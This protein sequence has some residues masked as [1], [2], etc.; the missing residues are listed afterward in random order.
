MKLNPT[1]YLVSAVVLAAFFLASSD[2]PPNARTGAPGEGLC[3]TGCHG[4]GGFSGNVAIS[5]IP[6]TVQAGQTYTVTLTTTAT[7][8]SPSVGGFQI[9]ALNSGNMNI[10]DLIVLNAAETGTDFSGGREYMEHRGD[11]NYSGNTVSW[12][13]DWQAPAGPNNE[14]ITF[15]FSSVMANN[16]SAFSGDNAVNSSF[17]VLLQAPTPPV[18]AIDNI[19]PVS[20][21]G[22][23]DGAISASASGGTPP[24]NFNWS[25]GMS[26]AS[27][28]GLT[29]GTYTLT[30]SDQAGQS[31]TIQ[32][33][34]SQP[35]A[36][37]VT[38]QSADPLTC[39]APAVV[40]V[41]ASGGTPGYTYDWSNGASG[42]QASLTLA[43]LPATVTVTD[44]NGCTVT[45]TIS[46]VPTDLDAPQ[47]QALGGTITCQ[48]PLVTLSGAGSSEGPCFSYQWTGPGGF[49]AMT[50]N[51]QV[52]TPGTY[53]LVV[54]NTCNGCTASAVAIVTEDLDFP[55]I[56]L[57]GTDT[58][59]CLQPVV[60]I[61]AG[62]LPGQSYQWS[63]QNGEI[64]Y[65]AD[66]VI[67]GVS[68]AGTYTVV[69]TKDQSGCT[70]TASV[71]VAGIPDPVWQLDTLKNLRCFGDQDGLAG[72]SGLGGLPPYVFLWPDSSNATFRADLAAGNYLVS[73][74]D[75]NGCLG[76][77]TLV[78]SGP[79]EIV[80]NLS[81]T[82]ESAPGAEDGTAGTAPAGGTPPYAI[83][84]GNGE[85]TNVISGLSPG[86][87]GITV[88]D[89]LGCTR[90]SEVIIQPFGCSLAANV[91]YDPPVCF[92][93]SGSITLEITGANG[94][95]DI[96]W[97]QG[98]SGPVLE[99]VP[100]GSYG[101]EITDSAGCFLQ[102]SA[103]LTQPEAFL[104]QPD[105]IWPSSGDLPDGAI[106]L[107]VSGGTPPYTFLWLDP[108]GEEAG[109]AE[110]L[111]GAFPGLYYFE[112]TDSNGC[113]GM[114][115][116]T[117]ESV[118][119]TPAWSDQVRL[120]PNPVGDLLTLELPAGMYFQLRLRD[121]WGR[122]LLRLDHLQGEQ[123]MPMGQLPAGMYILQV[124]DERGVQATY[125]VLR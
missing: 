48:Q 58:L 27:I 76:Q 78:I 4:G 25:N 32:A 3:S 60:E 37:L 44:D 93:D 79:Q 84:W 97:S 41:A 51:P 90:S 43:D 50:L 35:P 115:A 66:S 83:L 38:E 102:I 99:Q 85:T 65:G 7:S 110:D 13:F 31:A 92:G 73:I 68:K 94:P 104:I 74:T 5:G 49:S 72:L 19:T 113:Q 95:V 103:V 69:V 119:L 20:C 24:Y 86:T 100:A 67:V 18:P 34:V 2:N 117:I 70:A 1:L 122:E 47:A 64:A 111:V 53:T 88:T 57:S 125:R 12:T 16:N 11:K 114:D 21:N 55:L 30:V 26:G 39:A 10:G 81:N 29:A 91:L 28:S 33:T 63:T 36:L 71:T 105:S 45:L 42:P 112:V 62:F 23:N 82:D 89:S 77:D 9:V 75:Q 109:T 124:Q 87:Y 123:R 59:S 52:N 61:D 96:L 17:S 56:N 120:Y 80:L 6:G 116:F 14:T 108:T 118:A 46:S 98:S 15:Y 22:G 106:F 8:G 121:A 54:T 40:T 101:A 107:S